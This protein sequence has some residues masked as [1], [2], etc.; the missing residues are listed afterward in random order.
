MD[1]C[2]Y[3]GV[4][5]GRSAFGG[6]DPARAIR[7]LSQYWH[8]HLLGGRVDGSARPARAADPAGDR[9]AQPAGRGR[10]VAPS[11]VRLVVRRGRRTLLSGESALAGLERGQ[12]PAN[13]G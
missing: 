2:G 5:I 3:H 12:V 6:I 9:A 10:A 11:E 7:G 13:A 8:P 4:A 1:P